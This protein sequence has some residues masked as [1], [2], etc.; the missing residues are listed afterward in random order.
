MAREKE[1]GINK[2]RERFEQFLTEISTEDLDDLEEGILP[3]SLS[4]IIDVD[5]QTGYFVSKEYP[6]ITIGTIYDIYDA[7]ENNATQEEM[8]TEAMEAS[9]E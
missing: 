2:V 9:Q 4:I 6:D 5:P 7:I 8:A 3:Q 1:L